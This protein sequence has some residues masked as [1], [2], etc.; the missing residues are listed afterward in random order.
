MGSLPPNGVSRPR[1]NPSHRSVRVGVIGCGYWGPQVIRNF[2]E[3]PDA[4]L[5]VVAEKRLDRRQ[6]V[7]RQYPKV[8]TVAD[9]HALLQADID[10]VVVA[11]PIDTHYELARD[12]LLAGKHVL[13]EKPLARS[14]AEAVELMRLADERQRVLMV[15]HTFLYNP[16]VQTLRK[17]VDEGQLGRIYY[18]DS[19]RLN[20]GQ[21]QQ[22]VDVIWDLAP[23]D[24]SIFWYVLQRMPQVV[25]ARGSACVQ[26]GIHD[27]AYIELQFEGG[28]KAQTHVSWLDPC[29]VR[30]L[31][32]VGDRK[33]AVYNDVSLA[34][35]V[36]IYNT[37]V[38]QPITDSFG[39][40]QLSYRYGEMVAPYIPW[41]EPLRLQSE[42][43]VESVRSGTRPLTDAA[44]GVVVV[45]VLEA[46]SFSLANG[47]IRVPV[48]LPLD[49]ISRLATRDL[50]VSTRETL[51]A[52]SAG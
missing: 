40:F 12:A 42:H 34:E 44:Q 3:M 31:T 47:G 28:V 6:Y 7:R 37:G 41:Q 21:F 26:P 10:C 1:P 23:H 25:S 13:V 18:V 29:K 2:N 50:T 20:L 4:E 32:I 19:A 5:V 52:V 9:H 15:G 35:K 33:M 51:R 36:R 48:D 46:A 39:E 17:L 22:N 27:V 8:K 45:A 11:T 30:R 24:I 43:F 16:A 14:V 49:L 38:E